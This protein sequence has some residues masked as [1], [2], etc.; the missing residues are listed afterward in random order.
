MHISFRSDSNITPNSTHKHVNFSL[1]KNVCDMLLVIQ[2]MFALV[3]NSLGVLFFAKCVYLHKKLGGTYFHFRRYGY[4]LELQID[5]R[6]MT[7]HTPIK[8]IANKKQLL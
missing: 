6:Q 4:K 7:E 8:L 1:V 5:H 3:S 2:S